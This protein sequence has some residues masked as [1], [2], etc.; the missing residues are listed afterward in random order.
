MIFKRHFYEIFMIFFYI[1]VMGLMFLCSDQTDN[2]RYIAPTFESAI[3]IAAEGGHGEVIELLCLLGAHIDLKS[4]YFI[5]IFMMS[6]MICL[7]VIRVGSTALH[8][9]SAAGHTEVVEKLLDLHANVT[10][11]N[12]IGTLVRLLF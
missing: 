10:L 1:F 2:K 5:I 9:A 8:K 6:F 11:K 12:K 7:F 3:H 4:R